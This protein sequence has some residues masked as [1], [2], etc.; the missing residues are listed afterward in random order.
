MGLFLFPLS[1]FNDSSHG[2]FDY[3]LLA[4]R[5]NPKESSA[6]L[7]NVIQ[8][9]RLQNTHIERSRKY[10]SLSLDTFMDGFCVV[11]KTELTH[12]YLNLNVSIRSISSALSTWFFN[13]KSPRLVAFEENMHGRF[14]SKII[15][16]N[17]IAEES[18]ISKHIRFIFA[19]MIAKIFRIWMW[20][21]TLTFATKLKNIF[22]G[23]SAFSHKFLWWNYPRLLYL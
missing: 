1:N 23:R 7:Q 11:F 4:R 5:F 17:A 6:S 8:A 18:Q 20:C 9:S 10:G 2:N 15:L 14:L 22:F 21:G 3:V 12:I 13:F 19:Q 16:K